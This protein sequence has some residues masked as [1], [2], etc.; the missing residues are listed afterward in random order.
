MAKKSSKSSSKKDGNFITNLV[1]SAGSIVGDT[2]S[3][4]MPNLSSALKSNTRYIKT[5]Y[6]AA[7][8]KVREG[9][10]KESYLFKSGQNIIKNA[11]SDIKTG[12]INNKQRQREKSDD[13]FSQLLNF[14]FDN[15]ESEEN[16]IDDAF[17]K[18]QPE[19]DKSEEIIND[20]N[21]ITLDEETRTDI[22]TMANFSH[23]SAQLTNRGF[24]T[25]S[26]HLRTLTIFQ[27][28]N[29]LKFYENIE[30]KLNQINDNLNISSAYYKDI[31][32]N[33]KSSNVEEMKAKS[34]EAAYNMNGLKIEEW[35]DIYKKGFSDAKDAVSFL[36][37]LMI[38]PMITDFVNN[39]LGTLG[40]IGLKALIPTGLKNTLGSLDKTI[41]TLPILFQ[42]KI[43]QMKEKGGF[44][45]F[46]ADLLDLNKKRSKTT[47]NKF[48]KG[49]ISFDGI[50][51]RS[52]THVIPGY[53]KRILGAISN[54]PNDNIVYDMERGKFVTDSDSKQEYR[55][56]IERAP[57]EVVTGNIDKLEENY[58]AELRNKGFINDENDVA[59]Y[60][61][62]L[63]GTI[64]DI[65][66][67]GRTLS[68][69]LSL[70]DLGEDRETALIL[71][72]ILANLN[73]NDRADINKTMAEAYIAY[74]ETIRRL[75]AEDRWSS[76]YDF[77]K[78][79]EKGRKKEDKVEFL[80][81]IDKEYDKFKKNKSQ[82]A[83]KFITTNF[84]ED[85]IMAKLFETDTNG[86]NAYIENLLDKYFYSKVNGPGIIDDEKEFDKKTKKKRDK[87]RKKGQQ[88][89]ENIKNGT[90]SIEDILAKN[91]QLGILSFLGADP[92]TSAIKS[93]LRILNG[94]N[95]DASKSQASISA[96]INSLG[97]KIINS[98]ILPFSTLTEEGPAVRVKV[99]G[100]SVE[101][102]Q[103][104]TPHN[105][106][107]KNHSTEKAVAPEEG[108]DKVVESLKDVKESIDNINIEIP[109]EE[110]KE[111]ESKNEEDMSTVEK[112]KSTIS[113]MFKD[114]T[115]VNADKDSI[116]KSVKDTIKDKIKDTKYGET[117]LKWGSRGLNA[118][119]ASGL[120]KALI[121]KEGLFGTIFNRS[122]N[123]GGTVKEKGGNIFSKAK[124]KGG[125]FLAKIL[126]KTGFTKQGAEDE[127]FDILERTTKASA[128]VID[129]L[130]DVLKGDKTVKQGV[131]DL[132]KGTKGAI[133][134]T[135]S[136]AGN[137]LH[138][139]TGAFKKKGFDGN[140]QKPEKKTAE[141]KVVNNDNSKTTSYDNSTENIINKYTKIN[142]P[143]SLNTNT[144]NEVPNIEEVVN[145]SYEPS[146]PI[147]T[148]VDNKFSPEFEKPA[149][150]NNETNIDIDTDNIR[151]SLNDI[152]DTLDVELNDLEQT[153]ERT[154]YELNQGLT[155]NLTYNLEDVTRSLN[156]NMEDLTDTLENKL[157]DTVTTVD[158]NLDKITDRLEDSTFDTSKISEALQ[159]GGNGEDGGILSDI[160]S[161][162][163][164]DLL[165]KAIGKTKL[166]GKLTSL[167]GKSKAGSKILSLVGKSGKLGGLLSKIGIGS[168]AAGAATGAAGT[169]AATGGTGIL[170]SLG[171]KAAGLLGGLGSGAGAAGAAGAAGTAAAS[172]LGAAGTAA[173]GSGLLS[174][175]GTAATAATGALGGLGTAAAGALGALAP[176]ALPA[177]AIGGLGFGAYQLFK[178]RTKKD[179]D[180]N[181]MYDENGNPIKYSWAGSIADKVK[182][183]FGFGKKDKEKDNKDGKEDKSIFRKIYDMTPFGMLTNGIA[184]VF[185][186]KKKDKEEDNDNK[187]GKKD[188]SIFRKI[189]DVTPLGLLTNGIKSVF[190]KRQVEKRDKNG[191]K[192]LDKNGNPITETKGGAVQSFIKNGTTGSYDKNRAKK[193][194]DLL[195]SGVVPEI[196]KTSNS[197]INN[198]NND[199]INNTNKTEANT[200]I[201]NITEGDT[202]NTTNNNTTNNNTKNE[203]NITNNKDN[204][205]DES[206]GKKYLNTVK[207]GMKFAFGMTP[208]GITT[209]LIQ[210]LFKRNKKEEDEKEKDKKKNPAKEAVTEKNKQ[211]SLHAKFLS[212]AT[213]N[214]DK[215]VSNGQ[216]REVNVDISKIERDKKFEN[217]EVGTLYKKM[218][219]DKEK[220]NYKGD[221]ASDPNTRIAN[222]L[223][224]FGKWLKSSSF[225]NVFGANGL[226]TSMYGG[227]KDAAGSTI[228]GLKSFFSTFWKKTSGKSETIASS[229]GGGSTGKQAQVTLDKSYALGDLSNVSD[230]VN[231][232]LKINSKITAEQ[233]D[234]AFAGTAMEGLGKVFMQAGEESGLDPLYIASHAILET[235]W[236]TSS[237]L[238]DKGNW[239]GIGAFDDS[240]YESAYNYSSREAGII[241]GAKWIAE[242][243]VNGSENQDTLYKMRHSPSGAHDYATDPRWAESIAEIML[244]VTRKGGGTIYGGVEGV[245]GGDSDSS[246]GSGA[247]D[248]ALKALKAAKA[249]ANAHK[250]YIFGGNLPPLGNSVG[251]D[252]SGLMQYAYNQAGV[253]IPRTTYTQINAGQNVP[254][255][256]SNG[257][258]SAKPGDLLFPN[259]D[260]VYMYA[261][262]NQIVEAAD[263]QRGI[264]VTNNYATPIAIRRIVG[265][266]GATN[267]NSQGATCEPVCE[268]VK[269]SKT[270]SQGIKLP[271]KAK[272]LA[273]LPTSQ[274][275]AKNPIPM[276]EYLNISNI[277]NNLEKKVGSQ[278]IDRRSSEVSN[279]SNEI[280]KSFANV[281]KEINNNINEENTSNVSYTNI[282]NENF[283]DITRNNLILKLKE[284]VDGIY[285]NTGNTNE[286][287]SSILDL[288]KEFN[289]NRSSNG[290]YSI[291]NPLN[292]DSTLAT[293]FQGK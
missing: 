244:T 56:T 132:Y 91:K 72:D 54:N 61:N 161:E 278:A 126:T 3:D 270:S 13:M 234:A 111:E 88:Q 192:L 253:D 282:T 187:D 89:S 68:S 227:L 285:T 2:A 204:K 20:L 75:S 159:G 212:T 30:E 136:K 38:K 218:N 46:I 263:E 97:S 293:I 242:N 178:K 276:E 77:G 70:S 228:S 79:S 262:N 34:L 140:Y 238:A 226:F 195:N 143:E 17:I 55:D 141:A 179:K 209:N 180:G 155:N 83:N 167:L 194:E 170:A 245:N 135:F 12:K 241:E 109:S 186:K 251:T 239:F 87:K 185:G 240:P 246:S 63:R 48:I 168:S 26:N 6:K 197:T 122:K 18:D 254:I 176:F 15:M 10:I 65:G 223:K 171:A 208:I 280:S 255:T 57:V 156:T 145:T 291:D 78:Y 59:T 152:D 25:V 74:Q 81:N 221:K 216:D 121:G 99:V 232:S 66:K 1:K 125:N 149:I 266:Q 243:F 76:T 247:S 200:F 211:S 5:T 127:V 110:K 112:A 261:G 205:K 220:E 23:A 289:D 274:D 224:P 147:D 114:F 101:A 35:V 196:S 273:D 160:V 210:G 165:G 64:A 93:I 236:G 82:K 162:A 21:N 62:S 96:V 130:N 272:T 58:V 45:G 9:D 175:L 116:L 267:V 148:E 214:K 71:R 231:K 33:T 256:G 146:N 166:G 73:N 151:D 106:M 43:P 287:L 95:V 115:G 52:I 173:A 219:E 138:H 257:L 150:V 142:T 42:S 102:I 144:S 264:R 225:T 105:V 123:L 184:S 84:G 39:P 259:R 80:E 201:N 128:N 67:S 284:V 189:Y 199:L 51:K 90:E 230:I 164:G 19:E 203:K 37:N 198:T 103:G 11:V 47:N 133:K 8:D 269:S 85:S 177:L 129:G 292:I 134:T 40:K 190:G 271:S 16:L 27:N 237:I 215:L 117:V 213:P 275:A 277:R 283:R 50:T 279:L 235:G 131:K 98:P 172:G 4:I 174:G 124:D 249:V 107:A 265:S 94:N 258:G 248:K 36:G 290:N 250:P 139:A 281:L 113:E 118:F 169:A 260:H 29:T 154:M 100:G 157:E 229:S 49:P 153:L 268:N 191:N 137:I 104:V 28:Q 233:L 182:G 286:L 22:K 163:G 183:L 53:L 181:V 7:K 288:L 193:E 119:A 32:E 252:C 86:K 92:K 69:Q 60:V 108:D 222:L 31:N 202:N 217:S 188:K 24:A 44:Q 120:G 207:R 206:F 158:H 14:D 41:G